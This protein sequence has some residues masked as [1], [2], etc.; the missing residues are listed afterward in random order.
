MS[1]IG[2]GHS[3][4]KQ[5]LNRRT[6]PLATRTRS[7]LLMV[8][9]IAWP[10]FLA[11]QTESLSFTV[12]FNDTPLREALA[13]L[14]SQHDIKLAYDDRAL[15][16]IRITNDPT[17]VFEGNG[18]G[19]ISFS[20]TDLFFEVKTNELTF[21]NFPKAG[22]PVY[23]ELDYKSNEVLTLGIYHNNTSSAGVKAEYYN[24]LPTGDVWKKT[25][26]DITNIVSEQLSATEYDIYLEVAKNKSSQ[27]LVFVDN[28]KVIF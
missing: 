8:L 3:E 21:N 9:S 20:T 26:M 27:P 13:E 25:Y 11:A 1:M 15:T 10:S 23:L 18:S 24:L 6:A 14:K 17:E 7:L 2:V 19:I 22:K 16:D 28:I 4:K 12:Q 5:R